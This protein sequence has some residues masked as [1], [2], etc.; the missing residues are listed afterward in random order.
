MKKTIIASVSIFAV[1]MLFG[2]I[3]EAGLSY[4]QETDEVLVTLSVTAEMT[5]SNPV[6]VGLSAIAGLTGGSST[7]T[8][9]WTVVTNN[10]AGYT[11]HLHAAASPALVGGAQGDS[12]TDYT[13]AS[14]G[15]PDYTFVVDDGNAEFGYTVNTT[16][17]TIVTGEI[18]ASFKNNTTTC[19]IG[20]TLTNANCWI[21]TNTS[22]TKELLATT[23]GE[24]AATGEA[25]QLNFQVELDPSSP[26]DADG[27][28][29][30]DTYTATLTMTGTML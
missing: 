17:T 12:I 9:T 18:D 28:V 6:D 19:N 20:A 1:V 10:N 24:T 11:L 13:E 29:I 3:A 22:G 2:V 14:A 15:V 21:S 7:G 4:A 16:G 25:I 8:A 23:T 26:F 30:E 27:F 5:L